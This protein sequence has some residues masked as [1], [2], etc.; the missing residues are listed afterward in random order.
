MRG[1]SGGGCFWNPIFSMPGDASH[2]PLLVALAAQDAAGLD[3]L[4]PAGEMLDAFGIGWEVIQCSPCG[5]LPRLE[6]GRRAVIV[7]SGDARLPSALAAA[8]G[9]PVIRVPVPEDG[10]SGLPLVWD[11]GKNLPAG[12]ADAE[13]EAFATV[14]IGV[15][16]AKN[17]ALLVVA[18][19][20]VEDAGLRERYT[21]FRARQTEAVLRG[22]AL[23]LE[24]S[25]GPMD[26]LLLPADDPRAIERAAALLAAGELV[27]LPT[28]TVYGLAADAQNP[29][30]VAAIFQAKDRPLFDPL[31]V[32]LPD[33]GWLER[34]TMIPAASRALVERLTARFWPGPLTLLLPRR[35]DAV[36][37]LVTAGGELVAVRRSAHPVFARVIEAFGRPLA[38]PSANRFGRISP[39]TGAHVFSELAGRIPLILDA[40]PTAHGLESTIVAL[41]GENTLTLLRHGP[42]T[43]ETLETFAAVDIRRG[44][45][46]ASAPGQ[47]SGHYAPRTPLAVLNFP[48]AR[49]LKVNTGKRIGFLAFRPTREPVRETFDRVEYLSENGDLREAAVNLFAALRRLDEAGLGGIAAEPVPE[50]GL[51]RAIMERLR[52][53]ASG[54]DRKSVV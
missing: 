30:A 13:N 26:T 20:A 8:T 37:D 50:T 24:L 2:A 1:F 39:T 44:E 22:A 35:P 34:V 12:R 52:R 42:V 23:T 51:G 36:P 31:I 18:M 21:A 28:E 25:L 53:A 45:T 32:H 27:A 16:G 4:A 54:S 38:A 47:A 5:S 19:L 46:A 7:A 29:E 41:E 10:R 9:L 11:E 49:N 14:A 43:V 17:A 15:A 40:G 3:A 6:R 33:A 48:S